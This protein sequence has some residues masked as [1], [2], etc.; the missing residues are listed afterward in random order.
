MR[1]SVTA[2]TT[3]H[4]YGDDEEKINRRIKNLPSYTDGEELSD[5]DV[6]VVLEIDSNVE[7]VERSND[8]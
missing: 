3:Y 7:I 1:K 2:D 4:F 6:R 8:A 5:D